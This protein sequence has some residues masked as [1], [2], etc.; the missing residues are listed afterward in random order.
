MIYGLLACG[1]R[2]SSRQWQHL[3]AAYGV[4]AAIMAPVVVSIHSIVGLD[5]AG[6]ATVGW[7]STEF[8]P[9]FVFGALLSGFAIVLL[10]VIPLR[11][12]LRL[13]DI[14]TGRHF[15][16]LCKLLLTSSLCMAYAYI[17]DVFTTY[18]G[19]DRAERVMFTERMFGYYMPVYWGTILFNVLLPQLLWVRRLRINQPVIVLICLGAVVGMWLER[20]EIVVTSLHRPH[21]PS[22]WGLFH[23]TFWDWATLFGTVGMFLSG[24]LLAVRYVPII[25]IH[26]MR[27]LIATSDP[28]TD[29]RGARPMSGV[30]AGFATEHALRHALERLVAEHVNGVETYTPVALE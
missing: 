24:I 23:G 13:E 10:L 17:M 14:I 4:M 28:H 5:F 27:S 20:Y 18:Y 30:L 12:L 26:E 16:V 7:H 29:H 22:S 6:G 15:D 19:G 11:R 8:P 21:L 9:F 2:G 25:S 1:F 3:H